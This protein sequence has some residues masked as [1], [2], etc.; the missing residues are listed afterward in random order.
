MTKAVKAGDLEMSAGSE[1]SW[2]PN[3]AYPEMSMC[4][5]WV[6][7]VSEAPAPKRP[8]K[9]PRDP[10]QSVRCVENH[11]VALP[12]SKV[13]PTGM[14]GLGQWVLR[15]A[16]S[17]ES[18][19]LRS[20]SPTAHQGLD[21]GADSLA[22]APNC[23]NVAATQPGQSSSAPG[24]VHSSAFAAAAG[25]VPLSVVPTSSRFGSISHP[26]GS[27]QYLQ[28]KLG[29]VYDAVQWAVHPWGL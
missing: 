29:P 16:T 26:A 25:H 24:L 18:L 21:L 8:R 15:G 19:N 1:P 28:H 12:L 22:G 2:P 13:L 23:C 7:D 27:E 4:S 17:H 20:F 14:Q 9:T 5:S 6:G 11:A 3:F 10:T